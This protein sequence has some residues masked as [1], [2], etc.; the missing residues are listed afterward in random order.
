MILNLLTN[1]LFLA[2]VSAIATALLVVLSWEAFGGLHPSLIMVLRILGVV[3]IVAPV[4][5]YVVCKGTTGLNAQT[6]DRRSIILWLAIAA[7]AGVSWYSFYLALDYGKQNSISMATI[8][9]INSSY[10]VLI[11]LISWILGRQQPDFRH[12][13]GVVLVV[14]G[15][16]LVSINSAPEGPAPAGID[17][18]G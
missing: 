13:L 9:T 17:R 8:S 12:L 4:V 5:I 7:S 14:A 10:V 3:A 18:P 6:I 2:I 11:L 1:W 16:Y 15:V